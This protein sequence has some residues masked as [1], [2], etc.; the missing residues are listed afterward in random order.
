MKWWYFVTNILLIVISF[1]SCAASG[2]A[3]EGS[4]LQAFTSSATDFTFMC[5]MEGFDDKI[6]TFYALQISKVIETAPESRPEVLTTLEGNSLPRKSKMLLLFNSHTEVT[7][8]YVR[9]NVTASFVKLVLIDMCPVDR[10]YGFYMCTAH[11]HNHPADSDEPIQCDTK[12]T[13]PAD[14]E[15]PSTRPNF[16]VTRNEGLS[17]S[18]RYNR[19]VANSGWYNIS[20]TR[21]DRILAWMTQNS[22]AICSSEECSCWSFNVSQFSEL[23]VHLFNTSWQ[24]GELFQCAVDR[25]GSGGPT[26]V[27]FTAEGD[28]DKPC[29][30][31]GGNAGQQSKDETRCDT[32]C[33]R[34]E[35]IALGVSLGISVLVVLI[36]LILPVHRRMSKLACY[37]NNEGQNGG[38]QNNNGGSPAE[39]EPLA[40]NGDTENDPINTNREDGVGADQD[41]HTERNTIRTP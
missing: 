11:Y 17:L 28:C 21:N 4:E 30:G 8:R 1:L 19:S 12:L 37:K 25:G 23:H 32:E 40:P 33:N 10:V 5:S 16:Y 14:L 20:I 35:R 34:T 7:G 2:A 27:N 15:R 36:L 29:D 18:C 41:L 3:T 31:K 24:E 22:S 13:L 9:D 38:N 6:A 26:V 39:N